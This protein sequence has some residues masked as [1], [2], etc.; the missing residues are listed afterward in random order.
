MDRPAMIPAAA[1]AWLAACGGSPADP[2]PAPPAELRVETV[3]TTLASPVHL[4]APPGDARLYVVEQQGR[5]RVIQ[6]GQLRDEPFLDIASGVRSG[7]EQG[8]LGLAFHPQHA[9]NGHFYLNYTDLAGTTR[10]VRYTASADRSRGEPASALEILEVAQPFGNHNGGMLAF[11]PDG[12]LYI[13][14]GDGGSGGDPLGHGQNP[15][16]LLGALLR[17]DVDGGQPYAIPPDN[18]FAGD[19]GARPEVWAIGLRNP[20]RFAFDAEGGMLY[21]ADVGQSRREEINVQPAAAPGLNYGWNIMEGS[22]CY[23]AG[24]VCSPGGLVLPAVEYPNP[25]EG[26]AVTGGYVYRGADIPALRGHYLYAD[27][28]RGRVRSFRFVGGA[29]TDDREWDLGDLGRITSFGQDGAGELY[30]LSQ[31]GRVHRIRPVP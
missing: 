4:A 29:V 7:G 8:L 10:I 20:W 9:T 11:G 24:S 30:I 31:D 18:P 26:C 12:M 15:G 3:A 16:T 22:L 19:A 27:F 2:L 6:N 28:C 5:I 21:I 25:G 14:M 23:P 1:V 13:G 17:I